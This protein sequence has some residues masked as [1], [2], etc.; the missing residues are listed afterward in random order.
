M[1]EPERGSEQRKRAPK[2]RQSKRK[3]RREYLRAVQRRHRIL[4][5][6]RDVFVRVGPGGTRTR[7]L[8]DAAGINEATMFRH[9]ANK[10][11]IFVAAVIEPLQAAMKNARERSVAFQNASPG[12]GRAAVGRAAA[13]GILASAKELYPL[14][15]VG[16]F[17]EREAGRKLYS[18]HLY[19]LLQQRG[20]DIQAVLREGVNGEFLSI[21]IFGI[22]LA[23]SVDRAFRGV[24]FNVDDLADQMS[25][26]LRNGTVP[27]TP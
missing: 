19:P 16:L 25:D 8:A 21:A 18:Q 10:E 4:E 22:A 26:L 12:S 9:F 1:V 27:R 7:D 17:G 24:P 14:L 15:A 3:P 6:A 11:E 2:T 23:L 13:R 20:K 5:S